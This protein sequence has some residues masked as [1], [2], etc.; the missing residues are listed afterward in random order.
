MNPDGIFISNG[1]GDP[2]KCDITIDNLEKIIKGLK[3]TIATNN[4]GK[5]FAKAKV[6]NERM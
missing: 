1:P 5:F 4:K 2:K 6:I 3:I